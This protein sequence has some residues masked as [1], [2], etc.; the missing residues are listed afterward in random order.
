MWIYYK[1][2]SFNFLCELSIYMQQ[3]SSFTCIWSIYFSVDPICQSFW[4][5]SW[6]SLWS[7]PRPDRPLRN[8]C[9]TNDYKY[10]AFVVLII[11][12]FPPLCLITGCVT[13]TTWRVVHVE[14]E[15]LTISQHLRSSPILSEVHVAWPL[16]FCAMLCRSLFVLYSW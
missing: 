8:V 2:G 4:L 15:L 13:R 10:V 6:F 5:L 7:Q 1:R 11:R 9:I 12:S 14:L 3:H 16:V